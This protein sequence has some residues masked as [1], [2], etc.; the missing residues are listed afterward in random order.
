M[1]TVKS[2]FILLFTA[3]IFAACGDDPAV[4]TETARDKPEDYPVYKPEVIDW[5]PEAGKTTVYVAGTTSDLGPVLWKNGKLIEVDTLHKY[6]G[7]STVFVENGDVYLLTYSL[8]YAEPAPVAVWKNGSILFEMENFSVMPDMFVYSGD[9]YVAGCSGNSEAQYATLWKN[10][11]KQILYNRYSS[12]A[13]AVHVENGIVYVV[14]TNRY[15]DGFIWKNGELQEI[16]Q[17]QSPVQYGLADMFLYDIFVKDGD[18]YVCGREDVDIE[19]YEN[20]QH[21]TVWKNGNIL[22]RQSLSTADMGTYNF[23]SLYVDDNGNIYVAGNYF[24]SRFDYSPAKL[25][26]NGKLLYDYPPLDENATHDS[27]AYSTSVFVKEDVVY[28]AGYDETF[29]GKDTGFLLKDGKKQDTQWGVKYN[30]NSIFV[31][32]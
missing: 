29:S 22:Y 11:E 20:M 1:R 10:G 28:W 27:R 6:S 16:P 3:V 9:V 23:I 8:N 24:D 15:N 32:N 31:V 30:A 2:V 18:V 7:A 19:N 17:T 25:W 14:L 21:V 26:K 13:K 4:E 5:R 12:Q